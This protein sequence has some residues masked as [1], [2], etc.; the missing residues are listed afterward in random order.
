VKKAVAETA[1][2]WAPEKDWLRFFKAVNRLQIGLSTSL[3]SAST[4]VRVM[5]V[6]GFSGN[7]ES[8]ESLT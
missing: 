5:P 8:S 7:V 3:R 2:L 6:V 4:I 1:F